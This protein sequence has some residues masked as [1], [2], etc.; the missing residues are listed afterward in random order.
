MND[1][2]KWSIVRITQM[3]KKQWAMLYV[4]AMQK[5]TSKSRA[6]HKLLVNF[7]ATSLISSNFFSFE[8]LFAFW[9]ISLVI[10]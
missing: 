5:Q 8:Q 2:I 10:F 9:A 4:I 1:W 7:S 3:W 6:F